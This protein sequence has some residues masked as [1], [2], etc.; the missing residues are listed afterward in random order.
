[1]ERLTRPDGVELA[2][3]VRGAGPT[4]VLAGQ[5]FGEPNIFVDL[6]EN[7]AADHRVVTYS[8]RGTGESSRQGPYD[9]Q[10]DS[11]DLE[12]LLEAVG[13]PALL[14]AFADG[15]SRAVRVA[16]RRPDLVT[17]VVS[18]AGNPVGLSAVEGTDALA[19]SES[20]LRALVEMMGTDYRGALRSMFSTGNPDWDDD[21]LRQRVAAT[22]EFLPQEAAVPRMKSWIADD[23]RAEA[24]A[25]GDRLWLLEDGSN[26]WF[27]AEVARKT[28]GILPEA[29]ILDVEDGAISRPDITAGVVR[30][31]TADAAVGSR[32]AESTT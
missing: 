11:E 26:P 28:R 24:L 20:V 27:P 10:T 3:S 23:A 8:L 4:V 32:S 2:W 1:M 31:L 13:P 18:P 12:A 22:V 15:C 5:F 7:L 14:V 30:R 21:R 25:L 16:A 9:I 19:A 29:H 6:I 17:A